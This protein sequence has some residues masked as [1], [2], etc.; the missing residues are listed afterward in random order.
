MRKDTNKMMNRVGTNTKS[1]LAM[2]LSIEQGY[3]PTNLLEFLLGFGHPKLDGLGAWTDLSRL[4]I[5]ETLVYE[6]LLLWCHDHDHRQFLIK[7]FLESPIEGPARL[8][9]QRNPDLFDQGIRGGI[10]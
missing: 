6:D 3:G 1:R 2:Y 10:A 8:W 9:V 7:D 5:A 4:R